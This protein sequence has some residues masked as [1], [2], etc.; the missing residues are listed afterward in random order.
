MNYT[1]QNR[2]IRIRNTPVCAISKKLLHIQEVGFMPAQYA[3][4][5]KRNQIDSYLIAFVLSGKGY[6]SYN[7]KEYSL[8]EG[9]GLF[10]DCHKP[11][12]FRCDQN[13]PWSV[14]W[15]NFNGVSASYYYEIFKSSYEI[16]FLP[17]SLG[18]LKKLV[19][20]VIA[21]NSHKS[22]NTEIINAK[23]IT[24]ILTIVIAEPNVIGPV[25]NYSAQMESV[26][27]YIDTHFT[28]NINLDEI[29][30]AFYINKYH[31]TREFKKAYGE[32][33]FQHIISRRINYAKELLAST[34]KSIEEIAHQCGFNDQSNFSR[35]F[36]K[37][38]GLCALTYRKNNRTTK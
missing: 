28:E 6:L 3:S 36:K 24:D 30:T 21:N 26:M 31:L 20:E 7:D 4:T 29:S 17:H 15:I 38:E 2:L 12:G 19:Y 32:T 16:V 27:E 9:Q 25:E 5:T 8:S 11:T 37:C 18:E 35:Q 33:I 13:N 10:I 14:L 1:S 23:L 34:D 22:V